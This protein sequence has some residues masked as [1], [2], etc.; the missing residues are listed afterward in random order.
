MGKITKIVNQFD[1]GEVPYSGDSCKRGDT[2]KVTAKARTM[3][4]TVGTT[5][6]RWNC[7]HDAEGRDGLSVARWAEN[8]A[9]I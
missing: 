1:R 5:G 9:L 2:W 7:Q 3:E 4:R 8:R 6:K